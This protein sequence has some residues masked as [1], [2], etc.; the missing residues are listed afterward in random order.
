MSVIES[1]VKSEELKGDFK[2]W[3]NNLKI[4]DLD[5]KKPTYLNWSEKLAHNEKVAGSSPVVG[6]N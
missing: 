3:L 4:E 6:T 1:K 5:Q 2:E